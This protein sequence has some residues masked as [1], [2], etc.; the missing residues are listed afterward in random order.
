MIPQIV[1]QNVL[2]LCKVIGCTIFLYQKTGE[3]IPLMHIEGGMQ[4]TSIDQM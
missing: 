2:L 4:K 3:E 1:D